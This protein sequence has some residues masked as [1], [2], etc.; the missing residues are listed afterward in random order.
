MV[1]W[2]F[3]LFSH[4]RQCEVL[5]FVQTKS[6]ERAYHTNIYMYHCEDI[7]TA[8][9]AEKF[10]CNQIHDS[11]F[12]YY[13]HNKYSFSLAVSGSHFFCLLL[14]VTSVP[15]MCIFRWWWN[16]CEWLFF[17]I[18]IFVCSNNSLVSENCSLLI[19]ANG[20]N[21]NQWRQRWRDDYTIYSIYY[22]NK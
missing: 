7:F 18:E 15:V 10:H 2:F 17:N 4:A 14:A 11:S 9:R 16:K 22:A 1:V 21:N 19:E 8:S 3:F 13:A 12:S 6:R 5:G 20:I